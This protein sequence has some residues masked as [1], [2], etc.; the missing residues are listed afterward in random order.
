MI[1]SNLARKGC[2]VFD[3]TCPLVTR[4]HKG[5]REAREADEKVL[6]ICKGRPD[7]LSVDEELHDEVAGMVGHLDY[8]LEEGQLLYA[9]VDRAYFEIDDPLGAEALAATAKYRIIWQTTL[10]AEQ[11]AAYRQS[12]EDQIRAIQP[13]ATFGEIPANFVCNA[14][15][16]RQKGV[17]QLVELG[18][19]IVVVTDTTS[20]NG[21]GYYHQAENA[22][23]GRG[24]R[25]YHVANAE[26]ARA[27][28]LKGNVAMT[29]SA[30]TPDRTIEEVALEFD[31]RAEVPAT[32][33][34]FTLPDSNPELMRERL[35]RLAGVR[36]ELESISA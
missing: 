26:E 17:S 3:A 9:P 34:S 23:A 2:E 28:G 8:R 4:T 24:L 6:Y 1:F 7:R 20:K 35:I 22:L 5:V 18:M 31:S 10:H 19:P 13:E 16:D 21:M 11:A 14:V 15:Q 32:D 36:L 12:L 29:A 33:R 27:I 25:A 30:S